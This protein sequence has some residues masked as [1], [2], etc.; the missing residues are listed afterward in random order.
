MNPATILVPGR[1]SGGR[2][3]ASGY[4]HPVKITIAELMY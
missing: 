3:T 1:W 4:T 2:H